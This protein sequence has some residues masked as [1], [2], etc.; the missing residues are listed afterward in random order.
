MGTA[1]LLGALAAALEV[2]DEPVRVVLDEVLEDESPDL[3]DDE[4]PEVM[5]LSEV[6]LEAE[7]FVVPFEVDVA[8][9][10]VGPPCVPVPPVTEKVGE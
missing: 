7:V 10:L 2:V 4:V 8:E 6:V 3:V 1:A 9:P 5:L